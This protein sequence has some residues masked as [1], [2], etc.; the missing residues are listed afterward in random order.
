MVED[1][2][3]IKHTY[4]IS[5]KDVQEKL[6]IKGEV[7]KAFTSGYYKDNDTHVWIETEEPFTG[8]MT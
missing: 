2:R 5:L 4:V 8:D 1:S 6:G 3:V 7:K